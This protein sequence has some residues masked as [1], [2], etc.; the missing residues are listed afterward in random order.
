MDGA[1]ERALCARPETWRMLEPAFGN[2][3][4]GLIDG[5]GSFS[6]RRQNRAGYR[7]SLAVALRDDDGAILEEIKVRLGLGCIYR[8][9]RSGNSN[10]RCT[11]EVHSRTDVRKLVEIL[12]E[13]PL[14]GNEAADYVVWRRAVEL[15]SAVPRGHRSPGA[16]D[17]GPM[18]ELQEQLKS[19]RKYR[20]RI[21]RVELLGRGIDADGADVG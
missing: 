17:W 19:V 15:W 2:W 4:A 11:W 21:S 12:D 3:L 9:G 6:I 20:P 18:V 10:P 5:E 7:A 14:R 8:T 1:V 16:R 13:Y